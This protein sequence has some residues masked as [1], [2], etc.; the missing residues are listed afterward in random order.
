MVQVSGLRVEGVGLR[1]EGGIGAK[2]A[3]RSQGAQLLKLDPAAIQTAMCTRNITAG[4]EVPQPPPRR[5]T[6]GP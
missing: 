1:V 5:A 2:H 3:A 4:N 6:I